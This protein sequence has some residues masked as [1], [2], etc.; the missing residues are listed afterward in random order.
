MQSMTFVKSVGTVDIALWNKAPI[1]NRD[2]HSQIAVAPVTE[3]LRFG[4]VQGTVRLYDPLVGSTP[5]QS[6]TNV[7]SIIIGVPESP[8]IHR[9]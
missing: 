6:W 9:N 3:T 1:W 2:T 8:H 5:L 4:S 7:N